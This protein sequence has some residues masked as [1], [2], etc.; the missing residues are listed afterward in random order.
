MSEKKRKNSSF[1]S[2]VKDF[3]SEKC[4]EELGIGEM[5]RVKWKECCARSFLRFVFL[6]LAKKE[7]DRVILS[8]DRVDFLE[9]LAFL[10]IRSFQMEA[11]VL[12][13]ER[14]NYRGAI[15]SLPADAKD[16]ILSQTATLPEEGCD[17]CRVLMIRAAFLSAGTVLDPQKGY[18]AAVYSPESAATRELKTVL[19]QF[20]IEAKVRQEENGDM[21]YLKESSKVEDFLSVMGAQKFSLELMNQKIEKSIRG[22]I[23]R[24]QNFDGANMKKAVNGAQT[25]IAA[26]HKLEKEEVLETLSDSLKHAAKLRIAYPEVSLAE[27]VERSDE[28][29]TKSGLNH[30][31]Q[32]LVQLAEKLEEETEQ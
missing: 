21:L 19:E 16:M 26:I 2:S 13:R 31:L 11:T 17:R 6:F 22:D 25:V 18:H 23:N 9:V 12:K 14:G 32:K 3:L 1:S 5:S 30:R 4:L 7:S 20:G 10:L 24:R 27:L 29:L 8:S 28:N 15:L